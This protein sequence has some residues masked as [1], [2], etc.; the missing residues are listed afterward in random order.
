MRLGLALGLGAS[1]VTG[2]PPIITA[3]VAPALAVLEDGDAVQGGFSADIDQASNYAS[4]AGTISGVTVAV[5]INA[6]SALASDTVEA[7]DAVVVTVTVTDSAANQR[8]FTL[9]RT[10]VAVAPAAFTSGQ[11]S[12]A[13]N[14][15]TITALPDDGGAAITDIEYRVNGGAEVSTGETTTGTY[16]IVAADGADVEIRA[17]NAVGAGAWS[18]TKTVSTVFDPASL[19]AGGE[20]GAWYEPS[21]TTCFTDTAGTTAAGVG[22]AVARVNDSSGNGNHATQVTAAARPILQQTAGGLYYLEFDGVDDSLTA[23]YSG[24]FSAITRSVGF[25][26]NA[27]GDF[28][29]DDDAL[30]NSGSFYFTSGN[31]RLWSGGGITGTGGWVLG[32]DEIAV[33]TISA[34]GAATLSGSG[35]SASGTIG[36]PTSTDGIRLGAS[37]SGSAPLN[38]RIYAVVDL[39]RVVTAGENTSL[40]AYLALKSGVTL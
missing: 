19:F 25:R 6:V 7:G 2:A 38:G 26:T 1:Q 9:S 29:L 36:P 34:A 14:E 33:A 12:V 35:N 18:D 20:D 27:N 28:I 40:Q 17:V 3:T 13:E 39:D 8:V 22:D 37:G 11:W 4:T 21:P 32:D 31:L 24:A 5:T 30:N 16:T 23:A 10:A 15:L